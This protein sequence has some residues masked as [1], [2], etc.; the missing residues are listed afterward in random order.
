MVKKL[1]LDKQDIWFKRFLVLFILLQPFLDLRWFNDGTFPEILGITIPNLV[2]LFTIFILS[3]WLLVKKRWNKH[4]GLMAG[5]FAVVA[6]YFVAHHINAGT[7]TSVV[8]GDFDY[9]LVAELFYVLRL[10]LPWLIA[11]M[12]YEEQLEGKTIDKM[13]LS[14]VLVMSL[15]IVITNLLKIA[16]GS[17]T[18]MVIDGTLIDWFINEGRYVSNQLASKG[19]LIHSISSTLLVL[20]SPYVLYCYVTT[21]RKV[22]LFAATTAVIALIMIG[23][24]AATYSALIVV[25]VICVAYFIFSVFLK[26]H[27]F[28]PQVFCSLVVLA[29]LG[30][31]LHH[32]SPNSIKVQF[33]EEYKE[34]IDRNASSKNVNSALEKLKQQQEL[35]KK[36][37]D[38]HSQQLALY[39]SLGINESLITAYPYIYDI[40]FWDDL[41]HRTIPSQRS[42]NRYVQEQ[43][44]LRVLEKSGNRLSDRLLGIG[45]SRTS[46]IYNLERDFVYQAYSLGWIGA[47]LLVGPYI[48]LL[49]YLI[50][51]YCFKFRTHLNLEQTA[52][53]LG[54]GLT[55]FVAYYS[56]NMI[57]NLN[58]TLILGAFIGCVLS[59]SAKRPKLNPNHSGVR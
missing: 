37:L 44:F 32:Y 9:S 19:F 8:P 5:Y 51:R 59:Q 1:G 7:F 52:I 55:L 54:I 23:T 30:G 2:R 31:V 34:L 40:E 24:K 39:Q 27:A 16:Y 47:A 15:H 48:L 10:L 11:F 3:L 56:G 12:F 38:K 46:N 6:V 50:G 29:V 4:F 13:V 45:Y 41:I 58:V 18:T 21:K 53:I 17:Y 20:L 49:M 14:V 36:E 42:Q 25:A 22:F 28:S 26:Q 35:D 57:D 43:I 33:D